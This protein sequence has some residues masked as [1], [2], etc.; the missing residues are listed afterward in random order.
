MCERDEIGRGGRGDD[1]EAVVCHVRS[2]GWWFRWGFWG[3]VDKIKM[4]EPCFR[5]TIAG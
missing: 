4:P 5:G 3:C 2:G 1:G